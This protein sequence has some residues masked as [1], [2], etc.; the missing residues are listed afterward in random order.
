MQK[1]HGQDGPKIAIDSR[2]EQG[3]GIII[4]SGGLHVGY[5]VRKLTQ[6]NQIPTHAG[7]IVI[8]N[9][10]PELFY[11]LVRA[12]NN[13]AHWVF[14]KGH[15]EPGED[16]ETAARREVREEA[17]VDGRIV[18][19]VGT[20]AFAMSGETVR[21]S[22]YL[23]RFRRFV[24]STEDRETCW[25]GFADA[26]QRLSFEDAREMLRSARRMIEKN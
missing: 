2:V 22:Y 5:P 18:M 13:P 7:G 24:S 23:M 16:P 4:P 15:I 12:R 11:L 14:P 17:R 21:V 10:E 6:E 20:T 26:L 8:R 1:H 25:C 9:A 19:H 3:I